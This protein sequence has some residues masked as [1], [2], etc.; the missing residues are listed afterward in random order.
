M[1]AHAVVAYAALVSGLRTVY[2]AMLTFAVC[3]HALFGPLVEEQSA[4]YRL[5]LGHGP[6]SLTGVLLLGTLVLALFIAR[7]ERRVAEDPKGGEVALVAIG[8]LACLA[9][10]VG[11][12][13]LS[14]KTIGSDAGFGGMYT[15]TLRPGLHSVVVLTAVFGVVDAVVSILRL[16][17][18]RLARAMAS[19]DAAAPP[20]AAQ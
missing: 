10:L 5:V 16:R 6:S 7:F 4:L 2:F 11:V 3:A 12:G 9:V 20:S 13:M 18:A 1:R 19:A 14:S 15:V 8:W 17:G